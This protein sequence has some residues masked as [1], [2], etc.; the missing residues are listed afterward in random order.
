MFLIFM[1]FDLHFSLFLLILIV[2]LPNVKVFMSKFSSNNFIA[3][4]HILYIHVCLCHTHTYIHRHIYL[5]K[6]FICI[7][8]YIWTENVLEPQF[9]SFV[10]GLFSV[11][12]CVS[13]D[14]FFKSLL[15]LLNHIVILM[16]NQ[17]IMHV[18]NYF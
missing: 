3:L 18:R 8:I 13:L 14:D 6:C 9:Y 2:Y 7:C 15:F 16:E 17:M 5:Y 12:L 4:N 1:V 10:C 11:S